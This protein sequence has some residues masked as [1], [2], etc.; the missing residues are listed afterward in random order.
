MRFL[1]LSLRIF[2]FLIALAVALPVLAIGALQLPAGRAFLSNVASSLASNENQTVTLEELYISFGLN[3]TLDRLKLAD[4]QGTWLEAEGLTFDWRPLGLITGDL[5]ISQISAS[6]IDV[7]RVPIGAE[8]DPSSS[9]AQTSG[10]DGIALPFDISLKVLSIAELNLGEPLLGAPVSLAASGSCSFALD[11][12]LIT[13][14]LDVHRID[15]ID[16]SLTAQAQFEPS[17]ETLAFDISVS[18]P[19]GGLA[20]RLLEVPDLPALLLSLK[21]DGP[22]TDWAANLEVAL[23]GRKTVT[24]SAQISQTAEGRNL[25]FDLDGDLEPL[26]PPAAQAFLLGTTDIKGN[27]QFSPEF[28]PR[29]GN[30]SLRTQTVALSANAELGS[31]SLDASG[32][33]VVS[34]GDNA[35]IALDLGNRRIAFGPTNVDFSVTGDQTAAVWSLSAGLASLQTT[36]ARTGALTLS[37]SGSGADLTPDALKTPFDLKLNVKQLVGLSPETKP[38]SGRLELNATG[39]VDAQ[40][41][42]LFFQSLDLTSPAASLALNDS[43]LSQ[44]EIK[45]QG[46]MSLGNLEIFSEVAGRTLGGGLTSSFSTN[47]NPSALSGSVAL[48]LITKDLQTGVAQADALLTDDTQVDLTLDLEGQDNITLK[49][50]SLKNS[51]LSANGNAQYE[52]DSLISELTA[53]LADLSKVDAQLSGSL[54]FS[55]KT[56]GPVDALNVEASASSDQI[57]LAGTPLDDL[58]FETEAVA[59]PAAPKATIK[60]SAK[61]NDQ[62]ISVDVELSSRDGGADIDPLSMKLAGNSINGNLSV[63]DLTEP[64]ETLAGELKIDA[65]D[66][67]SLS[68]LLLTE[69]GG[70]IEGTVSADPDNKILVLNVTGSDIDV[71]TVSIGSLKLKAN[72]AAPYAPETVS[73]DIEI[74]ELITDATPIHRVKVLAKPQDGGTAITAEADMDKGQKDGLTLAAH[75][76]EPETG[77]YLVALSELGL[78]YQGLK[79]Q[80]NQPSR[81]TY[82]NGDVTITPLELSLGNGSLSLAGKAGQSLDMSAELKSVPLNLANAF[83]PSLGLGGTL[84]GNATASGSTAEPEAKWSIT[85]SGLTATELRKNGLSDFSMTTT[86]TLKNN[87]INQSTKLNNASGLNFA[88]SGTIGLAQPNPLSIKLNGTIPT[89]ALKRP[90]LEA[91]I[92]SEGAIAVDGNVGGSA[93]SP[94]YQITATPADL[95]VTSL[96]TGLTVRNISGN[97]SVNQN[98][99]SINGVTGEIVTGGSLSASGTVGMNDGF[100]ADLSINLDNGRYVDPGLVTAEVDADLKI[101]GRLASSS[102]SALFGGSVTINKA[103]ISIPEYLPGAIPPVD[104]Q[105]I[106]ASKAIME[107]VAQIGGGPKQNQTQQKSIPPRLDILVSAPGRI[108]I[109][110]RGLDAEL[111]GNLKVVGTTANPQAIGA[112][113][114]KRG[115]LDILTRR[116]VF[117]RGTATFEGS[118]TPVIDF[119]ATTTVNDTSITVSVSGDADDPVIEFSSSPEL[120]QDEVLA[121]LLFG[122]SVGNLSATQVARLAAAIATL[123]GGSDTGPLATIRKSLGLDAIDINT[124]GDDGPSVAVG[125]YINDNIYVGVEQGTGSGS[126]R[127]KVD[128]DLDR[129]LKVRGEV[130]ADGSSKAGIFFEREY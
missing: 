76:S 106:H 6:L 122:K 31:E 90:L 130:G 17:A 53:K 13:A 46:R 8:E 42:S 54:E 55:A 56:S 93:S 60:S 111:Q 102:S 68:P 1:R 66:L 119:A 77:A 10:S 52:N 92:R 21:G 116:L 24:G 89:L 105:H 62:P 96:S 15:G 12:A 125:K 33:L 118:L 87:Q 28:S 85:G 71:P 67:A 23:D 3:I 121:L 34:A 18:E 110:G 25:E 50:L 80:L 109:R 4:T 112:F 39:S 108:F 7:N 61:L 98:Q 129:G 36:E 104:V 63:G 74:T 38:V 35:L 123:T 27:A 91:G 113:S 9:S 117:S 72:L 82:Q 45:A 64:L 44:D 101:T 88:S 65:P 43:L 81:I 70:R 20:A 51:A 59:D 19:R 41:Q 69:I 58:R 128:I 16:A 73:A 100:L 124:D 79:S 78:R 103:D 115:Q 32:K 40:S 49:S 99:A 86:G 114:L 75:I 57:L 94:T 37:A 97:A 11:P 5:N 47:L 120:P 22:L 48:S 95:K 127:V 84:S 30:L 26:A 2:G 29:S 126:S 107:Q 83:V 14:D